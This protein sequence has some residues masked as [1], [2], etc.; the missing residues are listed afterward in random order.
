MDSKSTPFDI[1]YA[2]FKKRP[3]SIFVVNLP[4]DNFSWVNLLQK[5]RIFKIFKKKEN[6]RTS[7]ENR[8]RDLLRVRQSS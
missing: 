7:S 6:K 5:W 4:P 3:I 1:F 8:T 2:I